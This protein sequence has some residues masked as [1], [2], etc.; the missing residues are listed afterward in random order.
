MT[1]RADSATS[2][3]GKTTSSASAGKA[4][5]AATTT[6]RRR[7]APGWLGSVMGD[8]ASLPGALWVFLGALSAVASAIYLLV[9]YKVDVD[10]RGDP[11]PLAGSKGFRGLYLATREALTGDPVV[12]DKVSAIDGVGPVWLVLIAI[13]VVVALGAFVIFRWRRRETMYWPITIAML[14]TAGTVLLLAMVFFL[15]TMAFLTVASFQIRKAELPQ[16]AARRAQAQADAE[17]RAAERAAA[18][19]EEDDEYE[20]EEDAYE[21]VEEELDDDEYEEDDV[22]DTEDVEDVYEDDEDEAG[23]D[24]DVIEVDAA[25][26]DDAIEA[27]N[28]AEDDAIV[29][30]ESTGTG[31]DA[32]DVEVDTDADDVEVDQ[33]EGKPSTK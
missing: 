23:D 17:A 8:T 6:T 30:A 27:E 16:Q 15:P 4:G 20:D 26:D 24:D 25:A 5:T 14:L 3:E 32:D 28:D 13:P 11:V 10:D 29:T 1:D 33:A 22:D 12:P 2:S 19:D 21:D 18:E 7:A 9:F 31:T